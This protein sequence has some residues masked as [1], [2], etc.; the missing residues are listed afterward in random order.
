[1][2]TYYMY[3]DRYIS[4]FLLPLFEISITLVH[5]LL[6]TS[7][8]LDIFLCNL[9]VYVLLSLIKLRHHHIKGT[10]YFHSIALINTVAY[11]CIRLCIDCV[12][13]EGWN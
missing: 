4:I 13:V 10:F 2:Y 5:V 7:Q 9:M 1:M 12:C 6:P 11:T 3:T 8:Y